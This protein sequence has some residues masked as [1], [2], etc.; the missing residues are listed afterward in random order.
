ML[1]TYYCMFGHLVKLGYV[2]RCHNLRSN[3]FPFTSSYYLPIV[4]W[5]NTFLTGSCCCFFSLLNRYYA[6]CLSCHEFIWKISLLCEENTCFLAVIHC[7]CLLLSLV[8]WSLSLVKM[9]SAT[10]FHS[11]TLRIHAGSPRLILCI[12]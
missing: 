1:S 3:W 7:L 6:W 11:S 2:T 8:K 12:L 5:L 4:V 10:D 9:V